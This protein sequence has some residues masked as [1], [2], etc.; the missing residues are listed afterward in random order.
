MIFE[1]SLEDLQP[2]LEREHENAG[3]DT[4]LLSSNLTLIGAGTVYM[5][6]GSEP[7]LYS[8][9]LPYKVEATYCDTEAMLN[10]HMF[11]EPIEVDFI[12][13]A[14]EQGASCIQIELTEGA[15]SL[16]SYA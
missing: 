8:D 1:F 9:G 7:A 12:I 15:V 6:S 2:L 4:G 16:T 5:A 3:S 10:E 14:I 13:E 11:I